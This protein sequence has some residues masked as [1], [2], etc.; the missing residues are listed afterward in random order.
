MESRCLSSFLDRGGTP[1]RIV[2][3]EAVCPENVFR[4]E[5]A[6][7][8]HIESSWSGPPVKSSRRSPPMHCGQ[9]LA[10]RP[11]RGSE[12]SSRVPAAFQVPGFSFRARSEM[13]T[14]QLEQW[15]DRRCR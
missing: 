2:R 6:G 4:H 15:H 1:K 8:S 14:S 10:A 12:M 9:G 7:A 3:I 11:A 5:S 13:D